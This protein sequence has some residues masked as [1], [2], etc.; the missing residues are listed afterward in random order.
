[1]T[2]GLNEQQREQYARDGYLF[3]VPIMP[4]AEAKALRGTL[5]AVEA[6][7]GKPD[8]LPRPLSNYL[9]SAPHLFMPEVEQAIRDPRILDVVQSILGP[10]LLVW[11][12]EFFTKEPGSNRHVGWHQD[13]TY[14]G[15][16]S[17]E[18]ELTAWLALSPVTTENGCMR[19]VA[20]S[21]KQGILPHR[22]TYDPTSLVSRGQEIE[23]GVDEA[24]ATPV[25]LAP[26][27]L[28]LHHGRMF[29]ASGPNRSNE[30]RIGLAVRY[31]TPE[32]RNVEGNPD[33]AMLVRGADRKGHFMNLCG[34][35][36]RFDAEALALYEEVTAVH[37]KVLST[38]AKQELQFYKAG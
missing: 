4:A 3:P 23:G 33:F 16:G 31:I 25:V 28:S 8:A 9:R 32:V 10:D 11:S 1:M 5:E 15:L 12:C 7:Y 21:H 37:A 14:W 34:G 22:D 26:G 19:F 27:E 13:L 30:R 36:R 18:H 35:G 29:H 2:T 17:T 24:R 38:G 6:R 20:G